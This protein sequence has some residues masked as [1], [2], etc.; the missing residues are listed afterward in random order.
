MKTKIKRISIIVF[1]STLLLFAC[2]KNFLDT[3]PRGV[4]TVDNFYKTDD[5]V[6]A[7]ALDCYDM[8]QDQQFAIW[9]SS[10]LVR[11]VVR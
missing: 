10:Y 4:L 8:T 2:S 9:S 1:A 7:G 6:A 11:Y 5:Q 3:Q